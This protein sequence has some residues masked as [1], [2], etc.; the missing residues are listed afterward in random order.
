VL[1]DA[2]VLGG[3]S[4]LSFAGDDGGAEGLVLP[5][6]NSTADAEL[7]TSVLNLSSQPSEY[8]FLSTTNTTPYILHHA[9][10]SRPIEGDKSHTECI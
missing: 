10:E 8:T 9:L 5:Y 2:V 7:A 1:I 6:P 4:G 3:L